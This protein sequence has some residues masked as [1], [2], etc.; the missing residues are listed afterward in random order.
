[1]WYH[2]LMHEFAALWCGVWHGTCTRDM[3]HTRFIWLVHVWNDLCTGDM[4]HLSM[5]VQRCDVVCVT[6]HMY[7]WHESYTF[8][9]TRSRVTWLIYMLSSHVPLETNWMSADMF[10]GDMTHC[11]WDMTH[12]IWD[13]THCTWNMTHCTWDMTHCTWDLTHCTWDMTHCIWDMTH[14]TWDMTDARYDSFTW[15]MSP[16]KI[17]ISSHVPSEMNQMYMSSCHVPSEMG[18]RTHD[19]SP[20]H[21][22]M[23]RPLGDESE[24]VPSRTRLMHMKYDSFTCDMTRSHATWLIAYEAWLV[25]VWHDS[26]AYDVTH[27][28]RDM[29]PSHVTWLVHVR[30]DSLH[31]RH[32]SFTCDMTRSHMTWLIAHEIWLLHMWHDSFICDMTHC[33]WNMT[34]SCVTWTIHIWRDSLHTRHVSFKCDVTCSYMWHD[35]LHTRHDSLHMWHDS[36]I[37][38]TWLIAH[39]KWH[40]PTLSRSFPCCHSR[41]GKC[42][43]SVCAWLC[44]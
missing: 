20:G 19:S 10:I 21:V 13:M 1:M 4:A 6:W 44:V 37:H 14:C 26:F 29:T 17:S 42:R 25:H 24:W 11:I 27:R 8:R 9:T 31:M 35:S 40:D 23:S 16:I 39:G 32:D 28:T 41:L 22:I 43:E 38:V 7:M 36:F 15:D 2:A 12:R 3:S 34:R 30:H 18:T 5:N 33:I